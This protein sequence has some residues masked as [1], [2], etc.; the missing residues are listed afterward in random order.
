MKEC[1]FK[2]QINKDYNKS[3]NLVLVKGLDNFLSNRD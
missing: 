3:N 2:P 1:S